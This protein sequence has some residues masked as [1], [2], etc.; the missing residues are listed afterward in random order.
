MASVFCRA[1]FCD[2]RG[3]IAVFDCWTELCSVD[4]STEER[5]AS[6][7]SFSGLRGMGGAG[8]GVRETGREMS[9]GEESRS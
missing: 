8:G 5:W 1:A 3:P 4:V 7:A 6:K 2:C 9:K